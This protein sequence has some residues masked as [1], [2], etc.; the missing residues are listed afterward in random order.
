MFR[1]SSSITI[2][3]EHRYQGPANMDGPSAW[4][5]QAA[6]LMEKEFIRGRLDKYDDSVTAAQDAGLDFV[7]GETGSKSGHGQ[8]G[9]SNAAASAIWMVDYSLQAAVRGIRGLHFHQGVGYNYSGEYPHTIAA[10]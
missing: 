5:S 1:T 8:A 7:L 3:S 6:E 4:P 9:V 10:E 2:V